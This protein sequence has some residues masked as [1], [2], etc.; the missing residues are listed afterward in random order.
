MSRNLRRLAVAALAASSMA[1]AGCRQDMH[2]QPKYKPLRQSDL[3][4]DGRA[5]RPQVEGTVARGQFSAD[6]LLTTGKVAGQVADAFPF[7][8]DRTRL[9]RGRQRF[10]IFCS[11]CHG[12]TGD[13]RGL[14]VL[15][16]YRQPPA[17]TIDRL[18]A[19]PAG[20]FFDVI[21]NGFGAMPDYRTQIPVEDRWAIVAYLRALQLSGHATIDDVPQSERGRLEGG[22]Q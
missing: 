9:D 2:N 4:A 6:S 3:F 12:R 18:R 15:R 11:P 14:V 1:G 20:Y 16:G 13:G 5:S 17:F 10:D 22:R 7:A 8:I 21:T 19:Q